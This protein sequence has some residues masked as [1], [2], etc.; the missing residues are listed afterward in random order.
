MSDSSA[1]FTRTSQVLR[2]NV[3]LDLQTENN[4]LKMLLKKKNSMIGMKV[5]ILPYNNV[6]FNGPSITEETY[7]YIL[8]EIPINFKIKILI[9]DENDLGKIFDIP[10]QYIRFENVSKL[11]N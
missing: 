6:M 8:Q 10:F 11:F 7:G 3:V 4:I 5:K 9:A 2:D 1:L